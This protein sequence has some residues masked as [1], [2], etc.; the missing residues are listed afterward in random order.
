MSIDARPRQFFYVRIADADGIAT[1]EADRVALAVAIDPDVVPAVPTAAEAL[2]LLDAVWPA[3]PG[4][5]YQVS[6]ANVPAATT[7]AAPEVEAPWLLDAGS[8]A[9]AGVWD[10]TATWTEAA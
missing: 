10:D 5:E 9:D 4:G 8:W 7:I 6:P 2:A 1:A 3:R